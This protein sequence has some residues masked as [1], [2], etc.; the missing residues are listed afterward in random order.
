MAIFWGGGRKQEK[1]RLKAIEKAID[2]LE[3]QT[4]SLESAARMLK[5]EWHSTYDKLNR[6]MGRLNAR[7]RKNEALEEPES[8]DRT[9]P[10]PVAPTGTHARLTAA[11]AKHG[12][13]P[14]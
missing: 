8:D 3:N 14:R 9:G 7:I 12:L 13:L 4:T 6:L 1:E 10:Y 2:G 11:R 5:L